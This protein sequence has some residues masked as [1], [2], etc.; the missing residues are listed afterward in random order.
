M[1][2]LVNKKHL[3][4]ENMIKD[5]KMVEYENS[6]EEL[7]YIE[8]ET[9][10]HYEM[11]RAHLKIEGIK[12]DISSGYRSLEKQ[13]NL[14]LEFMNKYGIDYAESVVAMPG[15]SE[16]HTGLAIDICLYNGDKLI[17]DNNE[18]LKCEDEFNKIH[19]CL[20]YFGFILRYPKGKEDIT[21]YPYEPW[22]IRYVGEDLAMEIGDLTLEEYL[23]R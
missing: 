14:F 18:L 19:S 10:R 4:N 17:D 21:G 2:L 5:F 22:H 9:F 8:S 1:I 13:E 12:I 6:D 16:H 3:F 15:T 7:I 11:L 23:E 20:K